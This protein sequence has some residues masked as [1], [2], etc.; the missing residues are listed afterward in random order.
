MKSQYKIR[1]K[2][3]I[4]FLL[5][6]FLFNLIIGFSSGTIPMQYTFTDQF[7]NLS[8][9]CTAGTSSTPPT[10]VVLGVGKNDTYSM[11]S[12]DY[13]AA[14]LCQTVDGGIYEV[15]WDWL[16][17]ITEYKD[18]YGFSLGYNVYASNN[19]TM[20]Y[21]I[22]YPTGTVKYDFVAQMQNTSGTWQHDSGMQV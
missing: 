21:I 15:S 2:I 10:N 14:D 5:S 18:G 6:L 9:W 8:N 19:Y 16:G 17:N 22:E 3:N 12:K 13:S 11:K 1:R 20:L 4:Y 7:T